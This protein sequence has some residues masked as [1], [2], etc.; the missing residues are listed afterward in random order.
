MRYQDEMFAFFD[1]NHKDL[2]DH[3]AKTGQL[4]D[5]DKLDT[6]IKEFAATFQANSK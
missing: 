6:A 5:T 4:P 2:L 3:I 1:S